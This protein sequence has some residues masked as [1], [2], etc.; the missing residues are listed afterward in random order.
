[1][2]LIDSPPCRTLLVA[3]L[4]R[5][6]HGRRPRSRGSG[7]QAD[8]PRRRRRA[9][10]RGHDDAR[11]C[12]GTTS[13]WLPDGRGWLLVEFGGDTK[14]EAD[15]K[16]RA[17]QRDLERGGRRPARHQDLRRSEQRSSMSGRC[18]RRGSAPPRSCPA[19]RTPGRGWEDSAVPPER[20]G[21]YLRELRRAV[22]GATATAARSTGT[23]ARAACTRGSTSTS[24]PARA[25]PSSAASSSEA[26]DLVVSLRRLA[27]G[28][29]RRRPV[30]GRAAPEDVRRRARARRSASSRRSG[31]PTGG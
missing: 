8:R 29:A 4:R 17:L 11:D 6:L 10:D 24:S 7:A 18:A 12:T 20:L 27:L 13:R 19:S 31:T 9:P 14:E 22:R 26:A 25:S 5:R 21:E 28:R 3:R 16:A 1:M 2:Q 30:A 23:S 15:D